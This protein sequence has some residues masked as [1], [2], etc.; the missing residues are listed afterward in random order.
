[1]VA[2]RNV[3]CV[4]SSYSAFS[5]SHIRYASRIPSE[6]KV[7]SEFC[8]RGKGAKKSSERA[9]LE[10]NMNRRVLDLHEEDVCS[11][12]CLETVKSQSGAPGV[13][14]YPHA[15]GNIEPGRSKTA[16]PGGYPLFPAVWFI[17]LGLYMI[18]GQFSSRIVL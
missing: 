18:G 8:L 4:R 15:L 12:S 7:S 16:G 1:G 13:N 3:S 5:N 11:K 14:V 10:S 2:R 17:D 6:F 9:L